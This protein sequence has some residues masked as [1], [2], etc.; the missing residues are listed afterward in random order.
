MPFELRELKL[1]GQPPPRGAADVLE[2]LE[3]VLADEFGRASRSL[4][5]TVRTASSAPPWLAASGS[6]TEGAWPVRVLQITT[7]RCG[8]VGSGT[9]T[10]RPAEAVI[11]ND[12]VTL[13]ESGDQVDQYIVDNSGD[14]APGA[15][16][17]AGLTPSGTVGGRRTPLAAFVDVVC[18]FTHACSHSSPRLCSEWAP[19]GARQPWHAHSFRYS[20]VQANL[21]AGLRSFCVGRKVKTPGVIHRRHHDSLLASAALTTSLALHRSLGSR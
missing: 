6:A 9:R 13:L 7:G 5:R 4:S 10:P 1:V 19:D 11:E 18:T 17:Q 12:R 15:R 2:Q 20:C 3:H 14:T 16:L 21:M 8:G